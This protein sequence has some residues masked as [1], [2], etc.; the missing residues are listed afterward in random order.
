MVL[1]DVMLITHRRRIVELGAR[2]RLPAVYPERE[3]VDAGGLMFNGASLAS[4]YPR[5]SSSSTSRPRRR[6][7]W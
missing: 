4:M 7:A 3:F 5:W 2:S 1:T 6:S